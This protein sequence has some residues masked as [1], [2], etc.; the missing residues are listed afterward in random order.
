MAILRKVPGTDLAD[1]AL[2]SL[3]G[4]LRDRYSKIPRAHDSVDSPLSFERYV[5]CNF[6][7]STY[8]LI[9]AYV[10]GQSCF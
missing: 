7:T 9:L 3:L 2:D 1:T 6:Q 8:S 10:Q 4:D 5:E